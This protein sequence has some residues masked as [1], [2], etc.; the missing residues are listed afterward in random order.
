M[1]ILEE[2]CLAAPQNG[3][4]QR[5]RVGIIFKLHRPAK[6]LREVGDDGHILKPVNIGSE[7]H[8][9]ASPVE[10][11]RDPYSYCPL[12]CFR[13]GFLEQPDLAHD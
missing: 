13:V 8:F 6:M 5:R 10:G 3:F 2:A 9:G 11:S 1:N 12:A 7:E 4:R